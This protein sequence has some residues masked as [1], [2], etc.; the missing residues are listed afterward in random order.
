MRRGELREQQM[1]LLFGEVGVSGAQAAD[2][3]H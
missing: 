2:L 3:G 1:Q